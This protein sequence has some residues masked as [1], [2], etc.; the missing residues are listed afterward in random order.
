M[1]CLKLLMRATL[2]GILA[3]GGLVHVTHVAAQ[4]IAGSSSSVDGSA[5]SLASHSAINN[6]DRTGGLT[7]PV[8]WPMFHDQPSHLG[9]N[10]FENTISRSNAQQ[11]SIAWEGVMG[12]IADNSSPAIANGIA[13]IG[14][15]DGRLYAFNADGCGQDECQPLWSGATGNDIQSSPTVMNN[16]VY[17]GSEDHKLYAFAANGCGQPD[18][19]PLWVGLTNGA[20]EA[21]PIATSSTV[22]V[23]SE[24]HNFYAFAAG[25]CGQSTCAPLWW[26]PTGG[27]IDSSPAMV[28]NVLYFGSQ[29]GKLYAVGAQGCGRQ[30]CPPLWTAQVGS[31]IFGSSPAVS[32][33][34]V[35]IASFN[36]LNSTDSRLY[37]FSTK[38]AQPVCHPLW[39]AAAGDFVASSPAVANG[40]VYIGSG[41]DL[42]YAFD[43]N[44]CGKA[45]CNFL[46]RGEAVGAQ[47]A[48]TSS[49]AVANGL[50]YVGENNGMVELFDANGCG[51]SICLPVTQLEIHNEQV[52]GSSPAVVNG[53]VYVGSA[54]QFGFPIGRLYVYKL[55]R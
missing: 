40:V 8:S 43:A 1:T 39:S 21:A 50:V 15:F 5:D 55:A 30:V 24:D 35:Y 13:Y 47:A 45:S 11:L 23:G 31:I 4:N 7:P 42:L 2:L 25:G 37:A 33:N 46:W 27:A 36:E 17:I 22:Y 32:N 19:A 38:C 9:F 20:V 26:V 48:L 28:N 16:T 29:D 12:D 52:V 6:S 53:S 41:D 44:G 3:W 18:C 49:P 34:V 14:S 10:P 54:D 51:Q